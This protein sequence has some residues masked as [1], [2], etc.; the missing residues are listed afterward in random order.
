MK[1]KDRVM[2]CSASPA[3]WT[4]RTD[5]DRPVYVR[6]RWG[7]LSVRVGPP[8]GKLSSAVGGVVVFGEQIGDEFDGFIEWREVRDR[9]KPLRIS[10]IL[11]EKPISK[12]TEQ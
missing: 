3:Q 4:G 8:G 6:Y 12:E 11:P 10:Q 2:T 9:I 5:G 7:Y 1:I